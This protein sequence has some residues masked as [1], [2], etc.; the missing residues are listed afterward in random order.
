MTIGTAVTRS[1]WIVLAAWIAGAVVLGWRGPSVDPSANQPESFLPSDTPHGLAMAAMKQAFP[2]SSGLSEAAV[3]FE[4]PGDPLTSVDRV[5]IE[6]VATRI[7]LPSGMADLGDLAGI[8]V[9]SPASILLKPNPLL[10]QANEAGQ[11]GLVIVS[12]PANFVTMRSDRIVDH[13]YQVLSEVE[14]P[15]G[16]KASVTGSSGFGHDYADSAETSHARTLRVTVVA[17]IVIL[18]L[19]YRSPLAALVPL[20]A[21]SM[22][23]FVAM[24]AL[25]AAQQF[26]LAVG[27]AERIFVV[28]LIYGAGT[29]YSLFFIS[30]FRE[31]LEEG[32]SPADSSAR[33]L[34]ATFPAILASAGTDTAG[35]LM[36]CFAQYGIFRTTGPAVAVALLV[37]LVAAVTL[38]PAMVAL[39]GRGVFWPA[40]P[41]PKAAKALG[42]G[43]K[44]I[45]LNVARAVT[46][47]PATALAVALVVLV[48]PALRGAKLTWVYD[49]LTELRRNENAPV[50][51][52]AVGIDTARRH[53]PVGEISPVGVLIT[54]G[55]EVNAQDWRLTSEELTGALRRLDGVRNVRSFTSP[56]GK[57]VSAVGQA[58]AQ[59]LAKPK[60]RAEYLSA[61]SKA[62]R[63]SV[64]LDE[65]G[66][67]L[68]AMELLA[69]VRRTVEQHVGKI[70]GAEVHLTGA[71]A[72]MADT[73]AV[74]QR[75][76]YRVAILALAVIFLMVVALLRDALLSA[77]MVASTVLSYFAT[78]GVAYWA[79]AGLLGQ[80]GLDWKVEVFLFVVMVAVGVDYNIFLASRLAQE[81]RR[82]PCKLATCR[83][84]IHTGP[85][86]SSCGLI[87][88]ATL[89]SLMAGDLQLLRQLGLALALGMLI[90]TFLVR[91]VLLPAFVV[92]TGRTGRPVN[93]GH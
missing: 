70:E 87:M 25:A 28:V 13:I 56:L 7:A 19:V 27:T 55:R 59:L 91:P 38:V 92:L 31:F 30:R 78:L 15:A 39:A 50:G 75:D 76:F 29:D 49:T 72:E 77:F 54:T 22:A 65:T 68:A 33:A 2:Q 46:S 12:I 26:G 74:T 35:L 4:R 32:V 52:A 47:R 89:G 43:R 36:L 71:T 37:A 80:E 45:W 81:A 41:S 62:M 73:K 48:I 66:F 17:V 53:W 88:A 11:A 79:F 64:I 83:A 34:N 82:L 8:S 21:I 84:I 3:V 57:E 1:R 60:I 23:A 90:D 51:N 86:I 93:F 10:S 63:L 44:K 61:D 18:L 85:V 40:R 67:S 42:I 9:R 69:R 16:L 58:A 6:A 20:V 14:L 5:A 24:K